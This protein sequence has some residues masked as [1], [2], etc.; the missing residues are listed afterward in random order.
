[1]N[2][3]V[4]TEHCFKKY[5]INPALSLHLSYSA[6]SI[7]F[8]L[9]VTFSRKYPGPGGSMKSSLQNNNTKQNPLRFY[10]LFSVYNSINNEFIDT[11]VSFL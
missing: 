3:N 5:S 10:C 11:P 7:R 2:Y 9:T 1:M 8:K 6:I 4:R